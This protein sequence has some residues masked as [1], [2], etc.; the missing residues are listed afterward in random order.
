MFFNFNR[1]VYYAFK[2]IQINPQLN[3]DGTILSLA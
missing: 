3:I 2:Q 1:V